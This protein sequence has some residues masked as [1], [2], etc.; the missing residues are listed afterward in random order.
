MS[1]KNYNSA[2]IGVDLGG[3]KVK[4]GLVAGGA[5]VS[6][7]SNLIPESS[8]Y[9]ADAVVEVV[10]DTIAAVFSGEVSGIGIGIPSMLDRENGIIYDVQN[11]K[12]WKE[13]HLK[14][15]LEAHF[16]VPV[17]M[18]NDANCF[19]MGEKLY[20]LGK[21]YE[22]FA[23]ITLGTGIGTGLINRGTLLADANCGSG[24]FGEIP[25]LDGKLEDYASGQF[26]KNNFKDDGPSIFVKAQ[27]NDPAALQSYRQFGEHLGQAIKIIM[28]A[29][30]PGNFILGGSIAE[31]RDYFDPAMR[32]AIE[33][34]TFPTSL[35]N[36][37]IEYSRLGG[38]APILGAAAVFHNCH[39]V[40]GR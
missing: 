16:Q 5:I 32:A 23:G 28:Y 24:E 30:D 21:N 40:K 17:V 35:K 8:E 26:F 12:S 25:Y 3:T 29:V 14:D 4:A 39:W 9:D 38:D 27:R 33:T 19:A 7:A 34:F 18:D 10:K 31:A 22:N 1:H 15:I 37:V 36:L 20:G 6:A 2:V 11:I 13:I